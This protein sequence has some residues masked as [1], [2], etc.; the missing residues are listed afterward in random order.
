MLCYYTFILP[1]D[2]MLLYIHITCRLHVIIHSYYLQIVSYYTF[3]LPADYMLIYICIICRYYLWQ[4]TNPP[5]PYNPDRN[6]Y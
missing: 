5:P 2:Y 3:I 6:R 1:A 4:P